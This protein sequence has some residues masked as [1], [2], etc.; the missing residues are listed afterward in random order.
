MR[1]IAAVLNVTIERSPSTP[2]CTE[3]KR[4]N[5]QMPELGNGGV[6]RLMCCYQSE[7]IS[8]ERLKREAFEIYSLF[9]ELLG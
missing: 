7:S 9:S 8:K 5:R 3:S 4:P 6:L 1:T 2:S